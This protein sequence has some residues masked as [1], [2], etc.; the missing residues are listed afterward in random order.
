MWEERFVRSSSERKD[1]ELHE[2]YFRIGRIAS[3]FPSGIE[4]KSFNSCAPVKTQQQSIC[5][6]VVNPGISK[7]ANLACHESIDKEVFSV[8]TEAQSKKETQKQDHGDGSLHFYT[9]DLLFVVHYR[10]LEADW[11]RGVS[12]ICGNWPGVTSAGQLMASHYL[13]G[14]EPAQ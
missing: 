7:A 1:E 5:C 13:P 9:D 10:C 3:S 4:V 6:W 2:A 12:I 8:D 14:T 11:C